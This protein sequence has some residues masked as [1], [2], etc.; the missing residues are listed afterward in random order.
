MTTQLGLMLQL[1][2]GCV[3]GVKDT[4]HE[5]TPPRGCTAS[6]RVAQDA[7]AG[8]ACRPCTKVPHQYA[9]GVPV[10]RHARSGADL[11]AVVSHAAPREEHLLL[12]GENKVAHSHSLGVSCC[13]S[14]AANLWVSSE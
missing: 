10:P 9:S 12:Q 8:G 7:G 1:P 6:K 13:H 14:Y 11:A 3:P 2:H 4:L 5:L